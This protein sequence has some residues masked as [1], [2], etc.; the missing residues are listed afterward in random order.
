VV[1]EGGART[2][3]EAGERLCG[4]DLEGRAV[5]GREHA[6]RVRRV[7]G[8]GGEDVEEGVAQHERAL[9]AHRQV[10]GAPG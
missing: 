5:R 3:L 6:A 9:G 4:V 7:G 2:D 1:E 10:L 8:A